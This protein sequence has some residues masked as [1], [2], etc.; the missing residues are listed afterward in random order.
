MIPPG[1]TIG[2]LGGGQL[3][4]M[5]AIEARKMGYRVHTYEPTP[6]SS[7]GQVSDREFNASYEDHDQLRQFAESVDVI[8]YEFE[9][10][11]LEALEQVRTLAPLYPDP[12]VLGICQNRERE[13]IY[14]D[15]AGYPVAPFRIIESAE[16][17]ARGFESLGQDVILKT[18]DF[19]YDGKGQT[20][21]RA[22]SDP[23]AVWETFSAPRGVLEKR[24]PF[25][26]ECSVICARTR[27]G[28]TAT[29]PVAENIHRNHIL[30]LSLVPA[31][32]PEDV[33][34]RAS[35]L[36]AS[37]ADQM[38]VVGLLAVEFFVGEGGSLIVNELAPRPHNSGHY[39]FDACVTSQFEQQLRAVCGLPLGSVELLSPVVMVNLLGDLWENGTPAW[40]KILQHP[41]ARLHLYGKSQSRPGRKMGH[42]CLL[43]HSI[44]EA[45]QTALHLRNG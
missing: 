42:F 5:F 40:D 15:Q 20:S 41:K 26:H 12:A 9:N 10:I 7:A 27:E 39:T 16:D 17:L 29:F 8:T 19:G 24:I 45:H 25:T 36:A 43:A 31:R 1:A 3:G 28:Q 13:K 6:E 22:G 33:Q 21:L 34:R 14:L 38:K 4:R 37:I 32:L 18:A 23:A 44:E 35:D 2:L 30:D 11:P